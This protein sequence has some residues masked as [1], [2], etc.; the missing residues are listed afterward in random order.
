VSP[1]SGE[2]RSPLELD[3][4]RSRFLK[5][6]RFGALLQAIIIDG[7]RHRGDDVGKYRG[8]TQGTLLIV[9][10]MLRSHFIT[11]KQ[12]GGNEK[13]KWLGVYDWLDNVP[14]QR[15]EIQTDFL[16]V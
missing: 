13:W 10:G 15:F 12:S 9:C 1:L 5:A 8:K 4:V 6:Y 14:L 7:F 3:K 11:S 2:G 16:I